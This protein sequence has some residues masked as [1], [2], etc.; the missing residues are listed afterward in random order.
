M[1]VLTDGLQGPWRAGRRARDPTE[2][3]GR[4]RAARARIE[5]ALLGAVLHVYQAHARALDVRKGLALGRDRAYEVERAHARRHA[6]ELDVDHLVIA[7]AQVCVAFTFVARVPH[8]TGGGVEL[9]EVDALGHVDLAVE[10][11]RDARCVQIDGRLRERA[12]AG[13]RLPAEADSE[14]AARTELRGVL[15]LQ[16]DRAAQERHDLNLE[17]PRRVTAPFAFLY[18]KILLALLAFDQLSQRDVHLTHRV[19][20]TFEDALVRV[21]NAED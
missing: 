3:A 1:V 13:E 11:E 8:G 4:V 20:A 21:E 10:A 12:L 6:L 7:L 16:R 15:R 9:C 14:H 5:A 18:G 2:E 17:L 19:V